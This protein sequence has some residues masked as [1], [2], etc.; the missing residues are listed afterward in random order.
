MT[1]VLPNSVF[2]HIGRTGGHWVNHVLWRAGL[3]DKRLHPLHLTPQDVAS[4]E[5]VSSRKN[6]F[7]FVRHPL[8][9]AASVWRHEMEFGWSDS[10]LSRAA[11]A[12]DFPSF[13]RKLLRA[14]PNGPCTQTMKPYLDGCP[15]VGKLERIAED[16]AC[17]LSGAGEVFEA[18][19]LA[20]PPLNQSSI[21]ELVDADV[22]P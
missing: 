13:L 7:C 12:D 6:R 20:A 8:D 4:D 2:F 18:K 11:S 22:T 21:P 15:F 16:L 3:I 14:Y 19:C 5:D 9:W 17:A 10:E 1:I